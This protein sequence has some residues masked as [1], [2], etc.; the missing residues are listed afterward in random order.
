MADRRELAAEVFRQGDSCKA[1]ALCLF[2]E[3]IDRC[4]REYSLILIC[5][6]F[7]H[8]LP[9]AFTKADTTEIEAVG[10]PPTSANWQ[11]KH[12]ASA[13]RSNHRVEGAEAF[14]N[15]KL[16]PSARRVCYG[17]YF[18]DRARRNAGD[19]REL[20]AEAFRPHV[21]DGQPARY[22]PPAKYT[23]KFREIRYGQLQ[24]RPFRSRKRG[25]VRHS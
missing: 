11:R 25:Y 16:K 10:T 24:D 9:G 2:V 8:N 22:R 6:E 20:A 13:R 3:F 5:A 7:G 19:Q 15:Q 14:L 18:Y 12:S 1:A 23:V 17:C 21:K 4:C